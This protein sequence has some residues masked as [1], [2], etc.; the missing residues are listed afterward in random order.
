MFDQETCHSKPT[1]SHVDSCLLGQEVCLA[2]RV[3]FPSSMPPRNRWFPSVNS[4]DYSGEVQPY[5]SK[6]DKHEGARATGYSRVVLRSSALGRGEKN[7]PEE[8]TGQ[9]MCPEGL[10]TRRKSNSFSLREERLS[11]QP[12]RKRADLGP[13][14]QHF[15]RACI[16]SALALFAPWLYG[17]ISPPKL[18]ICKSHE[19][20]THLIIC[21]L[22]MYILNHSLCSLKT[23]FF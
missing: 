5:I 6:Q 18:P 19:C 20:L 14:L 16:S 21:F 9:Q 8:V 10:E 11:I 23:I 2:E 22:L 13:M 4:C 12:S 7:Y 3:K 1:V 15:V 17:E